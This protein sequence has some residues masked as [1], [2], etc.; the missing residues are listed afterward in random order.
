M[1]KEKKDIQKF[2]VWVKGKRHHE[3]YAEDMF[4]AMEFILER[5]YKTKIRKS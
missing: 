1:D 5:M 3:I 2:M 4:E